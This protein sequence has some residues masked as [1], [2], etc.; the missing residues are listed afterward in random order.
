MSTSEAPP[1]KGGLARKALETFFENLD[2]AF[3]SWLFLR[4]DVRH[5]IS[6]SGITPG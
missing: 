2:L 3:D 1:P 5:G 4:A 6:P